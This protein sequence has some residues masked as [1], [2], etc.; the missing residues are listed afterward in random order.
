MSITPA[1]VKSKLTAD[2]NKAMDAAFSKQTSYDGPMSAAYIA[3]QQLLGAKPDATSGGGFREAV[4]CALQD[5]VD[6][7]T[8]NETPSDA[9]AQAAARTCSLPPGKFPEPAV[10]ALQAVYKQANQEAKKLYAAAGGSPGDVSTVRAAASSGAALWIAGTAVTGVA[11]Y[12]L[13]RKGGALRKL[14]DGG[15]RA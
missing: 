14:I 7:A 12:F 15:R 11:A 10:M 1:E 8:V 9:D 4:S 13:L 3:V 5:G 2:A 6:K